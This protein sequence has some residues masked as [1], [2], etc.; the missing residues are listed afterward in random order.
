LLR[1]LEKILQGEQKKG[2]T[3]PLWDGH[4][5]DRIADVLMRM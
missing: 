4:A 1:E 2:T 3:P 5:G